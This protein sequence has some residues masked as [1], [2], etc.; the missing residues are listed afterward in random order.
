ME[1][2][3]DIKDIASALIVAQGVMG[4]A[5]KDETN[6]HFGKKYADLESVWDAC[7]TALQTAEIA[8]MQGP[9]MDDNGNVYVDTML[10]HKSGQ[11]IRTRTTAKPVRLD[12]QG[13]GSAITYLRRYGLTAM[14]GIVQEDDDGNGSSRQNDAPKVETKPAAKVNRGVSDIKKPDP[15][16][17]P[18]AAED[19]ADSLIAQINE[20]QNEKQLDSWVKKNL[21]TISSLPENFKKNV[22]SEY[23]RR[24]DEF[25]SVAA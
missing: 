1:T 12:P 23:A 2:S 4:K 9:G 17:D 5:K 22:R 13:V 21:P 15:I 10:T 24:S 18:V 3:P 25:K 11:F 19:T 14:L 7:K 8:V 20:I 16:V 6:P